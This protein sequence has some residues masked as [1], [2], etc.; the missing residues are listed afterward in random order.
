MMA[1]AVT[2][3]T[4]AEQSAPRTF[5]K[6]LLPHLSAAYNLA[7]WLTGNNQNAEDLVQEAYLRAWK[8]FDRFGGSDG[9]SWL[10]SIVRNTCYTWLHRN[11]SSKLDTAFDEEIHTDE[12][13]ALNPETALLQSQDRQLLREAME[14][15]PLEFREV[16]IMR[17][18]EEL[19]YREIADLTALPMGTVMS[20]LARAR[21]WLQMRLAGVR[22]ATRLRR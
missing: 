3:Q 1:A 22:E 12:S 14:E 7:R 15:L 8:A 16:L 18:L 20:R 4:D 2:A 13:E 17:E 11:G 10:L 21:K 9:R 5:E 6:L 19:S